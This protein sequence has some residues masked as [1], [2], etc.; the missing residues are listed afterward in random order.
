MTN[1][2]SFKA[3]DEITDTDNAES[4]VWLIFLYHTLHLIIKK[5]Y[6]KKKKKLPHLL[7]STFA[8]NC[9]STAQ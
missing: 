1:K 3:M 8:F 7:F 9:L 6:E 5:F 4:E 2:R